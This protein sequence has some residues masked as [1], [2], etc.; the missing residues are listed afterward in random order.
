METVVLMSKT[1]FFV[2]LK[3]QLIYEQN[4]LNQTVNIVK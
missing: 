1:L 4:A 2:V 3:M